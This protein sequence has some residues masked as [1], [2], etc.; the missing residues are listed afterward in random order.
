MTLVDSGQL[1]AF[2]GATFRYASPGTFVSLRSFYDDKA[3]NG[4]LPFPHDGVRIGDS[5]DDLIARATTAATRA[6]QHP[7][8]CR[9]LF[10]GRDLHHPRH[11]GGKRSG[12]RVDAHRASDD[13]HGLRRDVD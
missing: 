3:K 13:R 6:A 7:R 5:L 8:P 1:Q 10:A 12:R 11:R 4:A 2:I 9:L